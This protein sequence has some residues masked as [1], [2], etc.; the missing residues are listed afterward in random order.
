[1]HSLGAL[2]AIV[3]LAAVAGPAAYPATNLTEN[4]QQQLLLLTPFGSVANRVL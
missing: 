1:M 2:Q 3:S 4:K